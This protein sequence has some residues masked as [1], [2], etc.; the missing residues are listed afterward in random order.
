MQ[1]GAVVEDG[2]FFALGFDP[3]LTPQNIASTGKNFFN[4]EEC[5]VFR[6]KVLKQIIN[7]AII[8]VIE[9]Y[10]WECKVSISNAN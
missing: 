7:Y 10:L 3:N 4:D 8:N 6:Q 1:S 9:M 5:N 2:S